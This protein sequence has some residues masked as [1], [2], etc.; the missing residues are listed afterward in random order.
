M[1]MD[2]PTVFS[3]HP[4]VRAA[5]GCGLAV[6]EHEPV[7]VL[8]EAEK[9]AVYRVC[10]ADGSTLILK[11]CST[12]AAEI[13]RRLYE[14]LLP[15]LPIPMLRYFGSCD[16]GGTRWLALED[17]GDD[18]P[19]LGDD[20]ALA[21][22]TDFVG[23]LHREGRGLHA[24]HV[25]P[26]RGAAYFAERLSLARAQLLLRFEQDDLDEDDHSTVERALVLC[27]LLA[28]HWQEI[29]GICGRFPETLVHGDLV[30]E[31]L[32]VVHSDGRRTLLALDWEKA[33]WGCLAVDLVRVDPDGYFAANRDWLEASRE[34]FDLFLRVGQIF[35]Q[36]VHAW[37]EKSVGKIERGERRLAKIVS[38]AGWS[39]AP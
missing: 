8:E 6:A 16:V 5:K 26:A 34:E 25:L 14:A 2:T 23:T 13:E 36:F 24:R 38:D 39:A 9:S 18:E 35:R 22:L 15:E 1:S 7:G 32:R 19:A 4:A 20:T 30:E 17:A 28:A 31:N 11:R 3:L 10:L 37:T 27:D 33:G 29:E 21:V 12:A